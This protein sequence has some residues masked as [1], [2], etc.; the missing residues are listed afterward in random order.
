MNKAVIFDIDNT[1]YEYAP[2][3]AAGTDAMH[4]A[5]GRHCAV[6]REAF[7]KL[8]SSA[9]SYTKSRLKNTAACHNRMLYAQRICELAGIPAAAAALDMYNA[10]WD[11][12]LAHM[13]LY[14]GVNELLALL[15]E[16]GIKTGFCTDLTANIQMRKIVRLG[17]EN[18]PDAI[19]TS[20]ESG[21]EKP[22]KRMFQS[23][24]EKLDVLPSEAVMVGDD[25]RR[26]ICGAAAC[27]IRAILIGTDCGGH[28]CCERAADFYE[29]AEILSRG[30]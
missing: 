4:K 25:Y 17:L 28:P 12:F 9:K 20:E 8:L 23:V 21:I 13:R 3:D 26:D 5:F 10:Y 18:I 16:N 15:K 24:L 29:L 7:L 22:N 30:N 14:D 27:G 2:C 19:V 6:S 11:A 1:L